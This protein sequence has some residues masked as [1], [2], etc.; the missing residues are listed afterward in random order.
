MGLPRVSA[1]IRKPKM[2]GPRRAPERRENSNSNAT[3][4][5]MPANRRSAE[6]ISKRRMR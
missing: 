3:A 5:A 1:T 6:S 2:A 4:V